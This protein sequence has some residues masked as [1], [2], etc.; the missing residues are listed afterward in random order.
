[1]GTEYYVR[2]LDC[3]K[4]ADL[5]K[6]WQVCLE[7]PE[8]YEEV[9]K[10]IKD[11]YYEEGSYAFFKFWSQRLFAFLNKH[12]GHRIDIVSEHDFEEVW[13]EH[14]DEWGEEFEP[15]GRD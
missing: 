12:K 2:C 11:I 6:L 10:D 15:W 5:H 7:K 14:K 1:M 4:Y 9:E 3:K 8:S 13:D